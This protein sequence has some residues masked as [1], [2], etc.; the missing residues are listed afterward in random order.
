MNILNSE[1][2]EMV[3]VNA[4]CC[5]DQER[6]STLT[7]NFWKSKL[8]WVSSANLKLGGQRKS[9]ATKKVSDS[10]SSQYIFFTTILKS[11]GAKL[12]VLPSV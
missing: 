6:K 5:L 12:D 9:R 10:E 1:R 3:S 7:H 4:R 2:C 11:V 8:S